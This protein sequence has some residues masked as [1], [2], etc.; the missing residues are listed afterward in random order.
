MGIHMD[1]LKA[2]H[3]GVRDLKSNLSKRLKAHG[4]LVVT[5][6]SQPVKVLMD[7]NDVLNL[8]DMLDELSDPEMIKVVHE[9]RKAIASGVKGIPVLKILKKWRKN[10]DSL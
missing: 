7:Y 8:L 3:I 5:D 4:P 10:N 6:H 9:G 1:L 2:D